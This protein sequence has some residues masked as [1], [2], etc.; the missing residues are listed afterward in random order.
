MRLQAAQGRPDAVRR[1]LALLT[2]RLAD[3]HAEPAASTRQLTASLLGNGQPH[4]D[5]VGSADQ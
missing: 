5:G 4:H 1:T 2:A 3:L